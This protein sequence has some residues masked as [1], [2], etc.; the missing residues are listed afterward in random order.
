MMWFIAA[1]T[2]SCR[3][4]Q[5]KKNP[6]EL[7]LVKELNNPLAKMKGSDLISDRPGHFGAEGGARGAFVGHSDPQE[8][9]VDKFSLEIAKELDVGRRANQYTQLFISAQP[10]MSGCINK[11]LGSHVKECIVNNVHKDYTQLNEA[12]L[13]TML[14]GM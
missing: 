5:Y 8:V 1:N 10:H 14:K 13:L 6:A 3:I 11:H 7:T 2:N 9:E 12:E 4:F